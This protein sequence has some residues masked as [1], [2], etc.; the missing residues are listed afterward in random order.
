MYRVLFCGA[1]C[2]HVRGYFS[3]VSPPPYMQLVCLV[4]TQF[5]SYK[6]PLNYFEL[7]LLIED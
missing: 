4:C 5:H 2:E 3:I 7:M 1:F 6:E